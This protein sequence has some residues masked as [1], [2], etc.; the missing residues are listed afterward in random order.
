MTAL[1][2]VPRQMTLGD[3]IAA[4]QHH[5]AEAK[6]LKAEVTAEARAILRGKGEWGVPTW[7]RIVRE[8][9]V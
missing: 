1:R 2:A 7:E 8:F 4:Q 3:K 9:G 5:E 6:R